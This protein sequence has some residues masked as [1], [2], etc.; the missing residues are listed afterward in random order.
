MSPVHPRSSGWSP[1]ILNS[2]PSRR[3]RRVHCRSFH[4]EPP[5]PHDHVTMINHVTKTQNR[6]QGGV[7]DAELGATM[8]N[9][10]A[11]GR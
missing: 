10:E 3:S 2:P 7:R 9:E 6:G 8:R 11:G 1:F 5:K 4:S